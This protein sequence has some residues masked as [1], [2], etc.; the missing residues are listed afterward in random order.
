MQRFQTCL[1]HFSEVVIELRSFCPSDFLTHFLQNRHNTF[2][3][4][5]LIRLTKWWC[6]NMKHCKFQKGQSISPMLKSEMKL[7][8]YLKVVP[9]YHQKNFILNI[10]H[11]LQRSNKERKSLWI[12]IVR[13]LSECLLK[14]K[15]LYNYIMYAHWTVV[16]HTV[17]W[18]NKELIRCCS[19]FNYMLSDLIQESGFPR[20]HVQS[21]SVRVQRVAGSLLR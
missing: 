1:L 14:W 9:K 7:I 10:T 21:E 6:E 3:R 16:W 20:Q 4:K 19:L 11:T 8:L 5:A 18:D 2:V 17:L 12:E 13:F 15:C